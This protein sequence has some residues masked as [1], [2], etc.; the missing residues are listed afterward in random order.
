MT[1]YLVTGCGGFLGSHVSAALLSSGHRL[2]GIDSFATELY[3]SAPKQDRVASLQS[4]PGFEFVQ[5]DL[6]DS[7]IAPHL[8]DVTAV[9]HFAALAGLL[10]G[11]SS[12]AAYQEH[13]VMA[14]HKVLDALAG[15]G[16][17]LVHASTSSVYG[18]MAVG[19]E[20]TPIAPISAYGRSKAAAERLIEQYQ[21]RGQV[22]AT[23]LRLFSAYGPGQR[24]DMAYAVACLAM[25]NGEPMRIYGTGSQSRSNT[26]VSDV[27]RAVQLSAELRP[28]TT[29]N[30]AGDQPIRLIDALAVLGDALKVEPV[31]EFLPSR[32]GDQVS[33]RGDTSRARAVLGWSPTVDIRTGL[34]SQANW[35]RES[36]HRTS[37]ASVCRG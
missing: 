32:P 4:H 12:A 18:S 5:S 37:S 10:A 25:L 27:A 33:S 20:S 19:D 30:I 14:T 1:R 16:I 23:V 11:P 31:L 17:H 13:N 34:Q 7:S 24:P 3:P 28:Q 2:L 15:T 22:T 36:W 35:F 6:R 9:L 29:V 26:Y 21:Q 8:S